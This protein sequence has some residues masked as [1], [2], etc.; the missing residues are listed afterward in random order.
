MKK[1]SKFE[2]HESRLATTDDHG[3]RV[4]L[5]PEDV[6]GFWRHRRT[7]FFW[8]LII[9]Y[10]VLPWTR[11]GGKQTI[12]LD[13]AHREFTFFGHTFYG[14]DAPLLIF[15]FLGIPLFFGFVTSI[16]G[17]V[18]CGWGC[19]QTVFID[20]IYRNIELWT[21]GKAR[22]R[23]ALD[24]APWN[25][26][27]IARKGSK[28]I[29]FLLVSMHI[30][31]SFVGYFVGTRELYDITMAPPTEH[32]GVFV[33]TWIAT[34][35]ALFDFGWFRE[36]FCIIACPYGRFQSVMMDDHSMIVT[37]DEQRGEP[38]RSPEVSHENEGDC[39]NCYN[40]VKVCP[41]GIDIRRGTQMECIACTNCIDACDE[42][43]DKVGKPKGLI[44]YDSELGKK[45]INVKK[46]GVRSIIYL[47]LLT[48]ILSLF[49]YKLKHSDELRVTMLRGSK[50]TFNIIKSGDKEMVLNH[51]NVTIDANAGSKDGILF[52]IKDSELATKI[53]L[54]TPH[55]PWMLKKGHNKTQLF[56]RFPKELLSGGSRNITLL[57]L[58]GE[59]MDKSTLVKEQEVPL[60]GPLQ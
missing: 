26:V 27:K 55:I 52:K 7:I 32:W 2:R 37:Y 33:A 15:I 38:R 46:L 42:I 24:K 49:V 34:G 3:H 1:P 11:V 59:S 56:F 23:E 10:L 9:L 16:W 25:A 13:I 36:Q 12:L 60:A 19:P 47:T 14:H 54:K 17:R 21:E 44:R 35:I 58:T 30:G 53:E 18:W 20:A 29:L 8:F 43:M 57:I 50:T 48:V 5:Y 45:G 51:F 40:C 41:T 31:H 28:W 4:Y 22:A 6:K 39:I